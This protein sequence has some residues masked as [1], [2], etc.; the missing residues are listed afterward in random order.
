MSL[1]CTVSH[2]HLLSLSLALKSINLNGGHY[3]DHIIVVLMVDVIFVLW[4]LLVMLVLVTTWFMCVVCKFFQSILDKYLVAISRMFKRFPF[5][6]FIIPFSF[7]LKS[8][9]LSLF[10]LCIQFASTNVRDIVKWVSIVDCVCVY[11]EEWKR[12]SGK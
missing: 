3:L 5:L 8:H 2:H 11:S 4:M 6:L 9:S 10:H 12:K 1:Y 7:L